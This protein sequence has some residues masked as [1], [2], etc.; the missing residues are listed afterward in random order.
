MKLA[1]TDFDGTFAPHR[2]LVPASNIEAVAK[3]QAA[4]NKFGICT[5][6]GMSLIEFELRKYPALHPDYLVCNNGAVIVNDKREFLSSLCFAETLVKGML[7]LPLIR[8][9]DQTLLH[10]VIHRL[11]L[12]VQLCIIVGFHL[13]YFLYVF[14]VCLRIARHI[15]WLSVALPKTSLVTPVFLPFYRQSGR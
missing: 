14:S 11:V 1:A 15:L 3:W 5:G 12:F 7:R 10:G 2:Q 8:Q 4:G 6:R 13:S 9:T